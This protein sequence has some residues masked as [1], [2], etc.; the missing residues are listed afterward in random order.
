L[1]VLIYTIRDVLA[2][3]TSGH[4]SLDAWTRWWM[5]GILVSLY[6]QM[7]KEKAAALMQP[8]N[9]THL[10]SRGIRI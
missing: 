2:S 9:A 10:P 3:H 6:V 1:Y 7:L 8:K 4:T 5:Y